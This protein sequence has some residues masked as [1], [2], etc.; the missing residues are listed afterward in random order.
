MK[1]IFSNHF[2]G[3]IFLSAI[4][5]LTI[6]LLGSCAKKILFPVSTVIPTATATISIKKD[7]N[8][9]YAITF[10]V[11]N[12]AGPERLEPAKK[13]Y[14]VWMET[15]QNG[16]VNLGQVNISKGLKGS[17]NAI[18]PFKPTL[19]FVTAEDDGNI[20]FPGSQVVLKTDA[21]NL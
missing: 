18:S 1:T 15:E 11:K 20:K 19:F 2:K 16:T 13:C 17:L 14:V 6:F 4:A 9:N 8:M 10:F 7:K 12:I 21:V 3:K 5:V